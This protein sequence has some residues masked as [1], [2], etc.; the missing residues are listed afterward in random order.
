VTGQARD[1]HV[2]HDHGRISDDLDRRTGHRQC[3]TWICEADPLESKPKGVRFVSGYVL[4]DVTWRDEEGRREYVELIG[5]SL[6]AHE[7]QV[8]AL[9]GDVE[10]MEGD[11]QP[12]EVT[13]LISFPT[14]EAALAWYGS[15]EYSRA[16][17]IRKRSCDSRV[18]IFGE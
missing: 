6:T 3:S 12:G 10:V 8:V 14:R 5:P 16:L 4:A 2:D 9:S 15:D 13:V 11:W 17:D 7:G 18:M 1:L